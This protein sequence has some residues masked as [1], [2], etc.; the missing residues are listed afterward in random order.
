MVVGKRFLSKNAED[1]ALYTDE[2]FYIQY[3]TF[4][5]NLYL[6]DPQGRIS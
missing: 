1:P 6:K 4:N 5:I 2:S 3:N